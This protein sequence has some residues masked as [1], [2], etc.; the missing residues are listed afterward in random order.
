MKNMGD[1]FFVGNAFPARKVGFTATETVGQ[2]E[3]ND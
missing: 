3:S 1:N 2:P